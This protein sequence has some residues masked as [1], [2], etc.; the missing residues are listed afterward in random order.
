VTD[1][2]RIDISV[3]SYSP[4]L[5]ANERINLG[6]LFHDPEK[7]VTRFEHTQKWGRIAAFDDELDLDVLKDI[8]EGIKKQV[9]PSLLVDATNWRTFIRRFVNEFQFSTPITVETEEIEPFVEETKRIY[10][11][12]DYQRHERP[13]VSSQ[14]SYMR[15]LL[16]NVEGFSEGNVMG[17]FQENVPYD[18]RVGAQGFKH[19]AFE[20]RDVSK[21]ILS[22]HGWRD[23]ANEMKNSIHTVFIYDTDALRDPQVAIAI[24]MLRDSAAQV[25]DMT[26]AASLV[27][28]LTKAPMNHV[29]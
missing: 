25:L 17:T 3:F 13:S 5:V 11:R 20:N 16:K 9:E 23:I 27:A 15:K 24:A 28:E 8:F 2:R 18:Y 6:I 14:K 1:M 21:M 4:S 12:Y 26:Q 10:L 22:I 29:T 7:G 19:F